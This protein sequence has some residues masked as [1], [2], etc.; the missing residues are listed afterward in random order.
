LA[1]ACLVFSPPGGAAAQDWGTGQQWRSKKAMRD[2]EDLEKVQSKDRR[3]RGRAAP[4]GPR[5]SVSPGDSISIFVFPNS[6]YSRTVMVQPNGAI[7]LPLVGTISVSGLTIAQLQELLTRRY[8]AFLEGPQITAEVKRFSQKRVS[9]VGQIVRPGFFDYRD[10]MTLMELIA[11]SDGF[12]PDARATHINILRAKGSEIR[13]VSVNFQRVLDG[14]PFKNPVL[15]P[16]DA[17]YVPRQLMTDSSSWVVKNIE[18]WTAIVALV[19][20]IVIASK[21][22]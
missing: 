2:L 4:E 7:Q 19:G 14:D 1:L 13:L 5:E 11:L 6:D 15:L 20:T 3:P 16:G 22:H 21:T 17:V 8:S 18:P 10:G 12:Q 9:I